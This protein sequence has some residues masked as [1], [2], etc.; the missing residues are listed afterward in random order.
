MDDLQNLLFKKNILIYGL[1]KSGQACFKFLNTKN[2]CRVFD[3][4]LNKIPKKYK[5]NIINYNQIYKSFFDFIV[6]SPGVDLKKCKISDYLIKN[7]N[8]II[9]ELDIFQLSYPNIKKITITGTNGKSTTSKLLFD[10]LKKDKKDVRLTGNIGFPILEEKNF[11]NNTIF[12]IEASSYQL[13]YSQFFKS[14]YSLILNLYPDH[15]E[16]HGNFKN[17]AKAKFKLIQT[18]S[19]GDYAFVDNKNK[20][21]NQLLIKNKIRS[22]VIIVNY[23]KY[24]NYLKLIKNNYFNNLSNIQNLSF[25]LVLSRLL[26]IK[27]EKVFQAINRFKELNYRQQI[28]Y[29]TKNLRIIND[30]KSTSLSSTK[31][32]LESFEN[33]YWI[34]GGLSKKG[35]KFNLEKKYFKKIKAYIY[36]KDYKFF[37]NILKKKIPFKV[38]KTLN[39]SLKLVFED[40]RKNN[41]KKI[42]LF[43]PS[44]ASFDQFKNF[45]QRGL[46]FN[47]IIKKYINQ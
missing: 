28:I 23:K 3:D 29:D 40:L 39:A 9:S 6:L 8:K 5:N 35:D 18:Q 44:A 2:I 42:I 16:R 45:E 12:I 34:V 14:N 38:S 19:K 20:I 46:Y 11:N 31:F 32:L 21:I 47:K 26:K 30:S 41:N 1:G 36:G 17:Y 13:E 15:L 4:K 33:I 25:I 7:R 37:S 27:Y 24:L 22:K 43:S 10:V